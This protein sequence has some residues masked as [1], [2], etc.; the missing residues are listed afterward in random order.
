M[1]DIFGPVVDIMG[2]ALS[3]RAKRN[4]TIS[5][6]IANI[7]TPGYKAKNINFEEVM[8]SYLRDKGLK[9]NRE[10]EPDIHL[11]TTNGRHITGRPT[12]VRPSVEQSSERGVPNNVDLDEE[13]AKLSKNN[14]E[15]QLTT[16]MLI[17]KFE[18]LKTAITEGGKS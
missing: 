13:M 7:D 14:I 8:E 16:Q 11:R 1:K 3:L 4:A 2:K 10:G 18:M 17:K 5:S 9:N 15:Y 6:N 12:P